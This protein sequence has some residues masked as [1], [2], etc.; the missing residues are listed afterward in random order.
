MLKEKGVEGCTLTI[1]YKYYRKKQICIHL[2][3]DFNCKAEIFHALYLN[4]FAN[5]FLIT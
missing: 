5:E 1:Q 2:P 3:V 4:H